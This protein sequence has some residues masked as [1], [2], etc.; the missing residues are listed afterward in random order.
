[1]DQIF[2]GKLSGKRNLADSKAVGQMEVALW[3]S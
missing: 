3:T 2:A 1:M